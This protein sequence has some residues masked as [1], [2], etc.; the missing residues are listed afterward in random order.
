[1]IIAYIIVAIVGLPDKITHLTF[2]QSTAWLLQYKTISI[3]IFI[4]LVLGGLFGIVTY[5]LFLV[6]PGFRAGE[7]KGR[8][9]IRTWL[10][11]LPICMH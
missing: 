10:M 6:Y 5:M 1:L 4:V 7:K 3:S 2:S 9:L 8:K 11:L